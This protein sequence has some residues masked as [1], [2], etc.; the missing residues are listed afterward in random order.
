M[1]PPRP[2]QT[3]PTMHLGRGLTVTVDERGEAKASS[4]TAILLLHS[5]GGP[6]S[7]TTLAAALSE[8]SYVI[9][10]RTSRFRRHRPPGLV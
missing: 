6:Q 2:T 1:N 4:G 10:P 8:H 5:A 7:I 9:T 3:C